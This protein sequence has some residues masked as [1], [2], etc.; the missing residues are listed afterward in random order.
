MFLVPILEIGLIF[1]FV[2][3]GVFFTFRVVDFPDLTVDGSFPLGACVAATLLSQGV[4]PFVSLLCAA[5]AGFLA[6]LCTASI[7]VYLNVLHLLASIVTMTALYSINLR[8][9]GRPNLPL[10]G[11]DSVFTKVEFWCGIENS[12][13][14]V[15]FVSGAFL[16]CACIGLWIFLKTDLGLAMQSS[17]NNKT[18]SHS[19]GI[20]TDR[21]T[22]LGVGISN[23]LV[24]FAGGLFCHAQ[25]YADIGIGTGVVVS[26]L[27]S[28]ILS[29]TLLPTQNMLFKIIGASLGSLIYRLVIGIILNWDINLYGLKPSPSDLNLIT[30]L[31]VLLTLAFP[32]LR[33]NIKKNIFR[34]KG[35]V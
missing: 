20:H 22:Q 8:L 7:S 9:L 24:A 32:V 18:F 5:T 2:A 12:P 29:E 11:I 3:L 27:V 21:L 4:D 19:I 23:A 30:S 25:G 13:F 14:V 6:G 33:Q 15:S 16:I 26:G 35:L 10:M 28:V 34:E 1:S 17:G 31:M